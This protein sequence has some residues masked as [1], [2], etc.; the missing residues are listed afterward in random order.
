MYIFVFIWTPYLQS[1]AETDEKLPLGIIFSCFML[2]I[3]IGSQ[4]FTLMMNQ[5]WT[6]R[7]ALQASLLITI[8]CFAI[9]AI[10]QVF[11]SN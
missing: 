7:M 8:I 2:S 11:S 5:S 1:L 6:D 10:Y 4:L 9:I 3:M